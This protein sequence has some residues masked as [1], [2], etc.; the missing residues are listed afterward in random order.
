M[1]KLALLLAIVFFLAFTGTV[2]AYHAPGHYDS[3]LSANSPGPAPNSGDGIPDGSGWDDDPGP[4]GPFG[5]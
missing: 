3:T 2:M 5:D 4:F 1:K